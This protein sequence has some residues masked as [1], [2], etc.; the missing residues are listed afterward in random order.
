MKVLKKAILGF[1]ALTAMLSSCNSDDQGNQASGPSDKKTI[2]FFGTSATDESLS[3]LYLANSDGSVYFSQGDEISVFDGTYNNKF[4][5]LQAGASS[6]FKGSAKSVDTYY[7]L[8]PYQ[9]NAAFTNGKIT[10]MVSESQRAIDGTFDPAA[11]LS[12]ATCP[13]GKSFVLQNIGAIIR[14]NT[15]SPFQKIRL[16]SISGE[17]LTGSVSINPDDAS[18]EIL[19]GKSYA[20]LSVPGGIV[21][22]GVYYFSVLPGVMKEGLRVEFYTSEGSVKVKQ[23][24]R[25][26]TIAR[27]K[28]LNCGKVSEYD[29]EYMVDDNYDNGISS[30]DDAVIESADMS[31]YC[32]DEANAPLLVYSAD[33]KQEVQ[34]YIEK[35]FTGVNSRVSLSK[36]SFTLDE[37][38]RQYDVNENSKFVVNN[39]KGKCSQNST[40]GSSSV[41]Y[42]DKIKVVTHLYNSGILRIALFCEEDGKLVY[43]K[44]PGKVYI[45]LGDV[46]VGHCIT[47]QDYTTSDNG[48]VFDIDIKN[49]RD[50]NNPESVAFITGDPSELENATWISWSK[51][52]AGA[53]KKR[54]VID[55]HGAFTFSIMIA[56]SNGDCYFANPVNVRTA[57]AN[58]VVKNLSYSEVMA[59]YNGVRLCRNDLNFVR[60]YQ[61][62]EFCSRYYHLISP[63]ITWWASWPD[64][65]YWTGKPGGTA[66]SNVLK[67]DK[68]EICEN[69]KSTI[70]P[71]EGAIIVCN[72][73]HGHVSVVNRVD[74]KDMKVYVAQQNTGSGALVPLEDAYDLTLTSSGTYK[75]SHWYY[76]NVLGYLIPKRKIALPVVSPAAPTTPAAPVLSYSKSTSGSVNVK[77]LLGITVNADKN[78]DY[79]VNI[80][81]EDCH[82][83]YDL[84]KYTFYPSTS[85]PGTHYVKVTAKAV[86]GGAES[87]V[88]LSY[89]VLAPEPDPEPEITAPTI[90]YSITGNTRLAPGENLAVNIVTDQNCNIYVY[91]DGTRVDYDTDIKRFNCTLPTDEV[92]NHTVRIKASAG[93]LS[94]E[95]TFEFN[96]EEPEEVF[97]EIEYTL[98]PSGTIYRDDNCYVKIYTDMNCKIRVYVDDELHDSK[99]GVDYFKCYLPTDAIGTY[100][101]RIKA[102]NDDGNSTQEEFS[103]RVKREP[104]VEPEVHEFA[105][106]GTDFPYAKCMI[107]GQAYNMRPNK[108]G[109]VYPKATYSDGVVTVFKNDGSAFT[110]PGTDILIKSPDGVAGFV[111]SRISSSMIIGQ[112]THRQ[113]TDYSSKINVGTLQTNTLYYVVTYSSYIDKY[114]NTIYDAYYTGALILE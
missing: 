55:K 20:E 47:S 114:G 57:E 27:G 91:V 1:V 32:L 36:A 30:P 28:G 78:C 3:K 83:Q 106:C 112:T 88:S 103:Y 105:D 24:V 104:V 110:Q 21:E 4:S 11:C 102:T 99:T 95:R 9:E 90:S 46:N 38:M 81:G 85:T 101:V 50:V 71:R 40:W 53:I 8:C 64:A 70:A 13:D 66:W 82:W 61:C 76:G 5:A 2:T 113:G 15:V 107:N 69:G 35:I 65:K 67:G 26:I 34:S 56:S 22:P 98:Y 49:V 39:V 97:P 31:G 17:P 87:S 63:S 68:F 72:G 14:I 84:S 111:D 92:G 23:F 37:Y 96:V 94:S 79:T 44:I 45:K 59:T 75:L 10:A 80:D 93:G 109:A 12:V 43:F 42:L 19:T 16:V 73:D 77:E 60:R 86:N 33:K 74:F 89:T 6:D 62:T 29:G 108:N 100:D 48:L 7:M 41:R 54:F 25:E 51:S 18:V 52:Y 58:P